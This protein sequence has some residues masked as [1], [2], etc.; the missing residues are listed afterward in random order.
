MIDLLNSKASTKARQQRYDTMQ[1]QVNIR[2]AQISKRLLEHKSE[3][4]ELQFILEE[5]ER[6]YQAAR[7]QYQGLQ[8]Q[9][10][11]RFIQC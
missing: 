5:C 2:K 4:E 10:E 7:D 1:E 8:E 9:E 11:G 6:K 3:E